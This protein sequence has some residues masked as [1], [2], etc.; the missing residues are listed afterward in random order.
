MVVSFEKTADSK[1]VWKMLKH[2]GASSHEEAH[3]YPWRG[4]GYRGVDDTPMIAY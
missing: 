2:F 3:D 1:G 4:G